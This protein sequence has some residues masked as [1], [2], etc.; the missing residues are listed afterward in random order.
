MLRAPPIR[1]IYRNPETGE[2]ETFIFVGRKGNFVV[3]MG[4]LTSREIILTQEEAMRA[5]RP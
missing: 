5:R 3:Y 2:D 4:E 1:I